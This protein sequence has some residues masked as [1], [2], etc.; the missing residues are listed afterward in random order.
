MVFHR[1]DDSVV[2]E[3]DPY[4]SYSKTLVMDGRKQKK[5]SHIDFGIMSPSD[6]QRVAEFQVVNPSLFTMPSRSPATGGP[7]DPRLGISDKHSVCATCKKQLVDC[8]GHYG[9]IQLALPVFHIGFFKH[10]LNILQCI[11]KN[12]SR[13][14][15]PENERQMFLKKM[16]NPRFDALQK[17]TIFKKVLERCK[18]SKNCPYCNA[19]NG[20][21]KKISGVDTLKIVHEKYK[22][23]NTENEV[24][25]LMGRLQVSMNHNKEIA[26]ALKFAN[27]DLLPTRVLELFKAIPDDDS[28]VLWIEPLMGGRPENLILQNFLLMLEYHIR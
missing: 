23:R 24:E 3:H 20:T 12:C 16:R 15:L 14:L 9:Y 10:T 19:S 8:A 1:K 17:A 5:I 22:S 25:D 18:K 27:E 11:C 4:A 21:V 26:S 7:L 6:I 13:V 28:E 2:D